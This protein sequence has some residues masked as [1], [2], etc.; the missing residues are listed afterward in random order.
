MLDVGDD[1]NPGKC[2]AFV[3]ALTKH[4]KGLGVPQFSSQSHQEGAL[5]L[6]PVKAFLWPH[7]LGVLAE[8]PSSPLADTTRA[9]PLVIAVISVFIIMVGILGL[10]GF[11]R[12]RQHNNRM[13]FRRLQDLP[14]VSGLT[15]AGFVPAFVFF[16]VPLLLY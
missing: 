16:A 6:Q 13:E 15:R 3:P 9:D 10:V 4:G 14:M 8:L 11:L 7:S 5:L 2:S 1:E 12:Y